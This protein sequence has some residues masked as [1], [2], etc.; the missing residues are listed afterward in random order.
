MRDFSWKY[1]MMTGDVDAYLLYKEIDG[2]SMD[3]Q[4][5]DDASALLE[6]EGLE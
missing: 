4:D 3:D 1:F 6:D 5:A 2:E